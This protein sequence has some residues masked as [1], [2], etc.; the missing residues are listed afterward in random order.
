MTI[1]PTP[2]YAGFARLFLMFAGPMLLALLA[3]QIALQTGD[4][5]TVVDLAFF[6]VLGGLP[7]GRWAEFRGGSPKT[8]E[9]DP[10]MPVHLRRYV[11]GVLLIGVGIWIAATL[12]SNFRGG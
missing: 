1:D 3:Y 10:A 7:L 11:V 12:I 8:A 6:F 5:P 9:G 2:T 4:R